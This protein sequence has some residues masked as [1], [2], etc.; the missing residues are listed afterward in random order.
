MSNKIAVLSNFA[1]YDDACS[2]Y[3][4]TQPA[5]SRWDAQYDKSTGW[6]SDANSALPEV[7]L[8]LG[9]NSAWSEHGL[10]YLLPANPMGG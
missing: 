6:P 4:R 8:S 3:S 9:T 5:N 2:H 10:S 7:N 1:N